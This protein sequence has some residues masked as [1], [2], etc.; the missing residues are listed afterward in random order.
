MNQSEHPPSE[1]ENDPIIMLL[2]KIAK[3][4]AELEQCLK[5]KETVELEMINAAKEEGK[6]YDEQITIR[7]KRETDDLKAQIKAKQLQAE[8][9]RAKQED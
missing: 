1:P 5:L 2:R 9:L 7:Y 4:K 6:R 8:K 3:E